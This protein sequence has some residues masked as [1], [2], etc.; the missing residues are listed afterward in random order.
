MPRLATVEKFRVDFIEFCE[1]WIQEF[2][3]HSTTNGLK[4]EKCRYNCLCVAKV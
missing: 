1:H 2:E 3:P 4:Q